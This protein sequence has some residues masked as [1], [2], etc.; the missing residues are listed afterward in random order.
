MKKVYVA[1]IV[2]A[3]SGCISSTRDD[4]TEFELIQSGN[5]V[6]AEVP[7]F[8]SCLMVGLDR[9]HPVLSYPARQLKIANG[10]R[11]ETTSNASGFKIMMSADVF[12]NGNVALYKSIYSFRSHEI[13][14]FASCLEKF[15]SPATI[16]SQ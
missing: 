2:L 6:P 11:V 14:A 12:D 3:I 9:A 7:K 16:S 10:Y 4:V 1:G 5:V 15:Q 8:I 13:E